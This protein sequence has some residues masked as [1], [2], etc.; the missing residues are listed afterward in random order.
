MT[1]PVLYG[2]PFG[3]YSISEKQPQSLC[4]TQAA[5][6]AATSGPSIRHISSGAVLIE[7]P[8]SAYSGKTTRS[9][10][11]LLRRA[12][13]TIC[14]DA[15]GLRGQLRRRVDQRQLQLHEPDDDAVRRF[16]EASESAHARGSYLVDDSSPGLPR[17]TLPGRQLMTRMTSV[18][19]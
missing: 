14:D 12:L 15:L 2:L 8:C 1:M 4:S 17:A 6:K 10:P 5:W 7:R 13:P 11:A 18:S 16:V 9:R 3:L 19:T